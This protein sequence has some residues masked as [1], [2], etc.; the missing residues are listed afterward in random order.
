MLLLPFSF[1]ITT[2]QGWQ[3]Q[4]FLLYFGPRNNP[5]LYPGHFF[6]FSQDPSLW[7]SHAIKYLKS[8]LIIFHRQPAHFATLPITCFSLCPLETT[9]SLIPQYKQ[10]SQFRL[11]AVQ[12]NF[13]SN[14][15]PLG[16][17]YN[18]QLKLISLFFNK[19]YWIFKIIAF[20]R[21]NLNAIKFT[22]LK[23]TVSWCLRY[24]L[25]CATITII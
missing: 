16:H 17:Y 14:Q 10:P 18:S 3:L 2:K 9:E 8:K 1:C 15:A 4:S 12:V 6:P 23:C 5:Y 25:S 7:K 13:L 19:Q 22:F 11:L 21:Y 24:L 20:L